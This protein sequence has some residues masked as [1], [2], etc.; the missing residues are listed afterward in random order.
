VSVIK[1]SANRS[2]VVVQRGSLGSIGGLSGLTVGQ[3]AP[4]SVGRLVSV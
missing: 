4:F 2:V 1:I 3:L